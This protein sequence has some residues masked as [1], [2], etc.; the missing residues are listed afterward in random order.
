MGSQKGE[1]PRESNILPTY[2][3]A[4]TGAIGLNFDVLGDIADIITHAKFCYNRFRGFGVL[5]PAIL[6]FS[7]GIASRPY[8]IVSTTALHFDFIHRMVFVFI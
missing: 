7:I 3:D 6:Q 1:K 5:I 2:R 4:P 8:N